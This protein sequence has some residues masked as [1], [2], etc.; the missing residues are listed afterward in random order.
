MRLSSAQSLCVLVCV[1]LIH[2]NVLVLERLTALQLLS[3]TS[4][5]R[6]ANSVLLEE[7]LPGDLERECYE[8]VCS[9]EEAA[10]I[11]RTREKTMEFW[12]RYKTV[13]RCRSNLCLN[14]GLC[15]EQQQGLVQCL[16]A[17]RFSGPQCET[18]VR[19]CAYRNG[20]C[21]QYCSDLPGG[22]G[23]QCGCAQGYR[24]EEDGLSCSKTVPF[25]CGRQQNQAWIMTRSLLDPDLNETLDQTWTS[26][27]NWT[28][29]WVPEGNSSAQGSVN[30]SWTNQTSELQQG[31]AL[32]EDGR[33]IGG[34]LETL[35][36]SPWTVLIRREDGY[37]FCGGT[38]VSERWVISAAHCFH[39]TQAD[40]VTIGDVDKLRPDPGEQKIKVQKIL[41]HP[42]FHDYTFDSDLALVLLQTPVVFNPTA[43]PA[44]LPNHHLSE[45]LLQK[46]MMGVVSGWGTTQYMGRSSRFLRKVA[47]PVVSHRTC[48]LSTEQVVTDNM[49]CAGFVDVQRDS[50][51]G[52]SGGPFVVHFRGAWFLS[53]VVSWGEQCAARGKYGVYTRLGNFLSWIHQTMEREERD[54]DLSRDLNHTEVSEMIQD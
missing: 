29:T 7:V 47:L 8:E 14:G 54:L 6:R 30:A 10:E 51:S 21:M 45:A 33:I 1:H 35:G 11:F 13:P 40:H 31:A 42:H 26:E 27:Q 39:Q 52:D 19:E 4:R 37:G 44:C 46:N 20:G 25:P 28:E 9:E 2:C 5:R 15:S 32:S 23:V 48:S 22:A 18:E 49:F 3:S 16:C 34:T 12:Y 38:L 17:P 24:L 53:G 36:G 41:V 50:C 43:L